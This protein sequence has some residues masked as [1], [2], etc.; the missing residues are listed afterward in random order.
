MSDAA[1][2]AT[3]MRG[4]RVVVTGATLGIGRV[5]ALE[6]AR[7]G[8]EVIIVARDRAKADATV[9]ELM[10]A[11]APAASAVVGD[12]SLMQSVRAIADE[13]RGRFDR[14]DV[15]VNN[16]G[17]VFGERKLTAEGFERTFA[18][19]H[20]SYFL[21]TNLL[22]DRL[23]AAGQA[24]VVNVS[25][26]AH[27]PAR[28]DFD[29]LQSEKKY[30]AFGAYCVSKLENLLFTFELAR[31]LAASGVTANAAHPGP[32]ASGF[33]T[34]EGWIGKVMPLARLFMLT[35]E[36]GART[37]IFLASSP[38][39]TGT[40]GKYFAKCKPVRPSAR[41]LDEA[42]QKRLWEVSAKLTGLSC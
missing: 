37:S 28:M 31:R 24:R 16:A 40:T 29:N 17:A 36:K 22:L 41:A 19:N 25:S 35:P 14:L 34:T 12:L 20:L 3:M 2:E 21:L 8:A 9:A 33:G 42:S 38:E 26:A 30:S 4:K 6:L 32:V 10:Q 39:L 23:Q 1:G 27:Q 7:R 18:L 11:G 5:T 13:L 15:L